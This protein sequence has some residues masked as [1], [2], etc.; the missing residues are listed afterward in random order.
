VTDISGKPNPSIDSHPLP[1]RGGRW[2]TRRAK[3]VGDLLLSRPESRIERAPLT[4]GDVHASH[5][6]SVRPDEARL[7]ENARFSRRE[8]GVGESAGRMERN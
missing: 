3:G 7:A 2:S 8:F 4:V 5:P 6:G 1:K